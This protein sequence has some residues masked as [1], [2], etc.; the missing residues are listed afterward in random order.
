[1]GRKVSW[2]LLD[3]PNSIARKEV[4]S[5]TFSNQIYI[6]NAFVFQFQ[7]ANKGSLPKEGES[8]DVILVLHGEE[9][10]A[11]LYCSTGHRFYMRWK[12]GGIFRK[13][14]RETLASAY[15]HT[16]NTSRI[17]HIPENDTGYIDFYSTGHPYIYEIDLIQSGVS[18]GEKPMSS[19]TYEECYFAVWAYD[20]L[21]NEGEDIDR[22]ALYTDISDI[23]GRNSESIKYKIQNVSAIDSRPLQEKPISEAKNYQLLLKEV[24]DDYWKDREKARSLFGHFRARNNAGVQTPDQ[25]RQRPNGIS[26]FSPEENQIIIEE[27]APGSHQ[28][29]CRKR[30]N[31]LL[32]KGRAYFRSIDPEGKL[33]C[34]ACGFTTPP[35]IDKEIIQLHH[36]RAIH[37]YEVQGESHTMEEALKN[38]IPLCPTCHALAHTRKPAWT[39]VDLKELHH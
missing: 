24:F 19:W 1:M 32:Q 29:S 15:M 39:L 33:R 23:I 16:Q 25:R 11:A 7:D 18:S 6:P 30:S 21:D 14:L 20:R 17:A 8:T 3:I 12:S 22:N 2:K 13:V 5:T 36:Q 38:L 26:S 10:Q 34:Q 27:G 35:D 37:E 31:K 28:S 9:Y 4:D